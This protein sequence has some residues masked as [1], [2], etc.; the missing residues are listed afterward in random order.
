MT[1]EDLE[2]LQ[3][4]IESLLYTK[5]EGELKEFTVSIK[6]KYKQNSRN[7]IYSKVDQTKARYR[8][9]ISTES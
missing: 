2:E 7:K 4:E 8:G 3:F 9:A 5:N 1:T 6:L